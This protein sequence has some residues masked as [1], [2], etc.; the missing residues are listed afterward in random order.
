MGDRHALFIKG[1]RVYQVGASETL[2]QNSLKSRNVDPIGRFRTRA[3]VSLNHRVAARPF[4]QLPSMVRI[5]KRKD[6]NNVD[7][8]KAL[9]VLVYLADR[10][11]RRART[12]NY[13]R[14]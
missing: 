1:F 8:L 2:D 4:C 5:A 6:K 11:N 14:G 12:G 9:A 7:A 3:H 13:R 10:E